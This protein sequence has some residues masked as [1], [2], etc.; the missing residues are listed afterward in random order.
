MGG[1]GRLTA[2]KCE[3]VEMGRSIFVLLLALLPL[4]ALGDGNPCEAAISACAS[5][6][7]SNG[8]DVMKNFCALT[9]LGVVKAC[10]CASHGP[11]EQAKVSVPMDVATQC[12][13][14]T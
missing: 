12:E 9:P 10:A 6:C 5:G 3:S 2:T 13:C 7:A 1:K 4:A 8:Q 11:V 14:F